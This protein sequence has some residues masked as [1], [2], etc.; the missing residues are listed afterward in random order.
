M[1]Y[2]AIQEGLFMQKS[3]KTQFVK[4]NSSYFPLK[5]SI[6]GQNLEEFQ[7]KVKCYNLPFTIITE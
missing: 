5:D 2:L 3:L 7:V 4:V 1:T 6:I